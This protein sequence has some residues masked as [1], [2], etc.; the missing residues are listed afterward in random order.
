MLSEGLQE[1]PVR[2]DWDGLGQFRSLNVP[3]LFPQVVEISA[4][5][6]RANVPPRVELLVFEYPEDHPIRTAASGGH[7]QSPADRAGRRPR[8]FPLARLGAQEQEALDEPDG[9]G[10]SA[11]L[12]VAHTATG[13][14]ADPALRAVGSSTP[15]SLAAVM[16]PVA[17][18][19]RAPG[20]YRRIP[21]QARFRACSMAVPAMWRCDDPAGATQSRAGATSI[22]SFNRPS[23]PMIRSFSSRNQDTPRRPYP[24]CPHRQCRAL[25]G[26]R[27]SSPS[28]HSEFQAGSPMCSPVT[29]SGRMTIRNP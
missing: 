28:T 26:T 1:N 27:H 5:A 6:H 3:L 9:R 29:P 12:S 16:F 8:D 21:S 15:R 18:L 14:R 11:P 17:R 7:L 25:H 22:S 23:T 19:S 20:P 10:I 4:G 13:V 24:Q 2:I